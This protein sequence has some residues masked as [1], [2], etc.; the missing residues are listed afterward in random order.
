MKFLH[1]SQTTFLPSGGFFDPEKLQ[2]QIDDL[3]TQV[4]NPNL[5]DNPDAARA[6]LQKKSGLEKTLN[7]LKHLESEYESL[8]EL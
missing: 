7:E 5:W 1:K 2:Q 4:N 8:N 6:V 3:N